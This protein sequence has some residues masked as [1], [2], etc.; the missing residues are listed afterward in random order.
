MRILI[1][2][3]TGVL[4]R[5]TVALALAAGHEVR[6]LARHSANE[7]ALRAAGATPVAA[8]LFAR[9]SLTAA[10]RGSDAIVNLATAIPPL[11][12]MGEPGAW[13]LNSRIRTQGAANIAHA[14]AAAGAARLIQESVSFGY[15]DRGGDWISESEPYSFPAV[16]D[17]GEGCEVEASL[18][19]AGGVAVTILRIGSLY[20]ADSGHTQALRESIRRGVYPVRGEPSGYQS[21]I[22]SD[23]AATAVIAALDAPPAIY[24]IVEDEPMTRQAAAEAIGA[25]EGR[26]RLEVRAAPPVRPDDPVARSQRV[27]NRAFRQ[28][29]SWRPAYP[30]LASGW[31][32]VVAGV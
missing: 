25:A 10:A 31:R 19:A 32:A 18:A 30:G 29:S 1:T 9:Q 26:N 20:S 16:R 7:E 3:A 23:D 15:P 24:N 11:H 2:G 4:G 28:A 12:R 21:M 27:S 22:H 13:D 17:R 5:R 8:D 14:A 6:A